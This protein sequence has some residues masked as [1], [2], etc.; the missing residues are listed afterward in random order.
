[1][2]PSSDI[3][4]EGIY[5]IHFEWQVFFSQ[6]FGFAVIVWVIVKYVAPYVKRAMVKQ[7]DD[8][9]KQ[10]EENDQAAQRLTEAKQVYDEGLAEAK[11]ELAQ[12]IE[13]AHADA[14]D[15]VAKMRE[16]AAAE[17]DRVR[18]QGR[19]QIELMRRQLIRDL[20]AD[21]SEQVMA[22]TTES[23][24]EQVQSPQIK[25]DAVERFLD[26]LQAMANTGSSGRA[27]TQSQWN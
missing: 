20:K 13:D 27:R 17:V 12:L 21:F 11:T 7:Q 3:L 23:V 25:S 14:D 9:R 18:K 15:I 2:T 5:Q 24:R 4:A 1:M 16:T 6:L 19:D 8:I 22:H 26:E 10:I